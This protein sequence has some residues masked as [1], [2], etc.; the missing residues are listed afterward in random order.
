MYILLWE[1]DRNVSVAGVRK[2]NF[3][4]VVEI[5]LPIVIQDCF[6]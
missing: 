6:A 3:L 2:W 5:H 1:I 4:D